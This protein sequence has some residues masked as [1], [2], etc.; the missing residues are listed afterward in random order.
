MGATSSRFSEEGVE[1]YYDN[2][3]Q[4]GIHG[5]AR[6]WRRSGVEGDQNLSN[7]EN[8]YAPRHG[9][10]G[11]GDLYPSDDGTDSDDDSE[12]ESMSED[13]EYAEADELYGEEGDSHSVDGEHGG[14][15]DRRAPGGGRA[16]H[17][18]RGSYHRSHHHPRQHRGHDSS[19]GAGG[20]RGGGWAMMR[21]FDTVAARMR[22]AFSSGFGRAR[23][24]IAGASRSSFQASSHQHPQRHQR[25]LY[26][27]RS[28]RQPYLQ[29]SSFGS[30]GGGDS[31]DRRRRRR[32]QQRRFGY[33]RRRPST[34]RREVRHGY[35][36]HPIYFGP[37]FRPVVEQS[38]EQV[39]LQRLLEHQLE[40][41]QREDLQRRR[42]RQQRRQQQQR[43]EQLQHQ[44]V[45]QDMEAMTTSPGA[46]YLSQHRQ[47]DGAAAS[48]ASLPPSQHIQKDKLLY[49]R[50]NH[51]YN[52]ISGLSVNP[53]LTEVQKAGM[54]DLKSLEEELKDVEGGWVDMDD[55]EETDEDRQD[56]NEEEEILRKQGIAREMQPTK[57]SPTAL[58]CP[59]NLKKSTIR[60]VKNLSPLSA[61]KSAP[62][63]ANTT[64]R[65]APE[66]SP[67]FAGVGGY[68]ESGAGT[69]AGGGADGA[70][71]Q[72]AQPSHATQ[73]SPSFQQSVLGLPSYRLDFMF[74]SQTPCDIKLFWVTKEVE[75]QILIAPDEEGDEEVD[76]EEP[77]TVFLGFRLKRLFHLPQ[78]TVYHFDAGL[79]QRFVSPI[80]PLYNLSLPELTMQGLP[81]AAMRM[82]EKQRNREERRLRRRRQQLEQQQR[83]Q[84]R[85][86]HGTRRPVHG[87]AGAG[88]GGG[89]R[90]ED[91]EY[92]VDVDQD[93]AD[94]L[95]HS[96]DVWET[97]SED[98]QSGLDGSSDLS[99][100]KTGLGKGRPV[101]SPKKLPVE[102]QYYPLIIVI[103]SKK[104]AGDPRD[105]KTL[106][107]DTP[108][109]YL[110][111]NEAISTFC[112]FHISTEGGFELKVMKQKV[113]MNA[114]HY[115]IQEIYGFTD[116]TPS[117]T[118]ATSSSGPAGTSGLTPNP[119]ATTPPGFS[120]PSAPVPAAFVGNSTRGE[121]TSVPNLPPVTPGNSNIQGLGIMEDEGGEEGQLPQFT[122][123]SATPMSAAEFR[124]Q[125]EI[126][127]KAKRLSRSLS[128]QSRA[129]SVMTRMTEL[130]SD[131]APAVAPAAGSEPSASSP[132]VLQDSALPRSS[133]ESQH[134]DEIQRGG[135]ITSFEPSSPTSQLRYS[136]GDGQESKDKGHH[137]D[138]IIRHRYSAST[139]LGS[140]TPSS[141]CHSRTGTTGMTI[142]ESSRLPVRSHL[143]PLLNDEIRHRSSASSMGST[144]AGDQGVEPHTSMLRSNSSGG[145][146]GSEDELS[147]EED[148]RDIVVAMQGMAPDHSPEIP[149]G[150]Q[151]EPPSQQSPEPQQQQQQQPQPQ[152]NT[153]LLDAPECVICL[154]DV[155]DTL[156][157]P[158]RHFCICSECA[159]VLRRRTPQRCPICRQE[160]HALIHLA[161]VPSSNQ[162][163][164]ESGRP[165]L[166]E[167]EEGE[168]REDPMEERGESQQQLPH[169]HHRIQRGEEGD[170]HQRYQIQ[171][172][173]FAEQHI[174]FSP[175]HDTVRA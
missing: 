58:A 8:G 11:S 116:A 26:A 169:Y 5:Y 173:T 34:H 10:R 97:D 41:Q 74:D 137:D 146:S 53:L 124:E 79:N 40:Q 67:S 134:I 110:V 93:G 113:W 45:S 123:T 1:G 31:D 15:N 106:A 150:E 43:L 136:H 166:E 103:E 144:A 52:L 157:L 168:A 162:Y 29:S 133:W 99:L 2:G 4:A 87:G 23:S 86:Q 36:H 64:Y 69:R 105:S 140:E 104:Q 21:A 17:L 73:P 128:R 59:V 20:S 152:V 18:R 38:P 42:E 147:T 118:T 62:E 39:Q 167:D 111:E 135:D 112:S 33:G 148:G 94:Q 50:N 27:T 55:E 165:S 88:T 108:G 91:A 60:L 132:C 172:P 80:L 127:A 51:L 170:S 84:Q 83:Q 142:D 107:C 171:M 96:A 101:Y 6:N 100:N 70:Y 89:G 35:D 120:L 122:R 158:C 139:L 3:R 155:K 77:T 28:H 85:Q 129:E 7:V 125:Q 92:L 161:S 54:I 16:N 114:N 102:D 130:L 57:R 156:V 95:G 164:F 48:P 56:L 14:P 151:Q 9:H 126:E 47:Y 98:D 63:N 174:S 75:E 13:D 65:A 81:S 90:W 163:F 76:G 32:H 131:S 24:A 68:A 115:L 160:F 109:L 25:Y 72:H 149:L 71:N 12:Y 121:A 46:S 44:H 61:S 30:G 49:Y 117:T 119:S 154:S 82:I 141:Q 19:S 145:S 175:T 138:S 37:A 153:V 143:S 78:P 159:D 22:P 66:G